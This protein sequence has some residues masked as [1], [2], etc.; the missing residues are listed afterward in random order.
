MIDDYTGALKFVDDYFQLN[1]P[2]F[3]KRYFPGARESEIKRNI[4][5]KKYKQLFDSLSDVQRRII[6]D[7]DSKYIVVAAGPGSGKTKV[8]VHK[9]ASLLLME[10]VKHEQLLM[11]TFSRAAATEFKKRLI[12]LIG[13]AAAYI[14][15][16]TFH[17]YCFDLLGRVGSLAQADN[18][19]KSAIEKIK[20]GDIEISR[21]T[22]TVLVVDE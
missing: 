15:I 3:L 21:I 20:S 10:D 22:K 18:V 5:P 1:F 6:D 2:S 12:E 8:L 11:V 17:S 7:K 4:T 13:N 19:L 14:E 9:L 16:K